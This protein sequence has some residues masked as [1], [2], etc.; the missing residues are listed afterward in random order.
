MNAKAAAHA[1]VLA[2]HGTWGGWLSQGLGTFDAERRANFV[3][4]VALGA[5]DLLRD[6]LPFQIAFELAGREVAIV[7]VFTQVDLDQLKEPSV[8][9]RERRLRIGQLLLQFLRGVKAFRGLA[10]GEMVERR[11]QGKQVAARLR[12]TDN[13]L[14]R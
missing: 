2:A 13:L 4:R 3:D 14:R 1:V 8:L 12:L 9:R 6:T 7:D 10:G 11:R 5:G